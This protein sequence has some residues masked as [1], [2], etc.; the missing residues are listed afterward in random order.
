MIIYS[1][2]K[3]L[4][5]FT[6]SEK[7]ITSKSL[8]NHF[9]CV[10]M[11]VQRK[12]TDEIFDLWH[13]IRDFCN[14]G[15]NRNKNLYIYILCLIYRE[16]HNINVYAFLDAL[17][18]SRSHFYVGG[19]AWTMGMMITQMKSHHSFLVLP[20]LCS[21]SYVSFYYRKGTNI[22]IKTHHIC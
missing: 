22:K 4:R 15:D 19:C 14:T 10:V 3:F 16:S 2:N 18:S 6:F 21:L 1:S 8:H 5:K 9:T 20:F 7:C 11:S 13:H 12:H 17:P